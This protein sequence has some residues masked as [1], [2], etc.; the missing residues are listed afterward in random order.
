[1]AVGKPW[2]LND[3]NNFLREKNR[4]QKIKDNP[5]KCLNELKFYFVKTINNKSISYLNKYFKGYDNQ[6]NEKHLSSLI[7]EDEYGNIILD[8]YYNIRLLWIFSLHNQ[9]QDNINAIHLWEDLS[10]EITFQLLIQGFPIETIVIDDYFVYIKDFRLKKTESYGTKVIFGPKILF[11]PLMNFHS[12]IYTII[13]K[14]NIFSNIQDYG[15][16]L[17]DYLWNPV[18][19]LDSS[20]IFLLNLKQGDIVQ[21]WLLLGMI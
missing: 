3:Y 10:R 6:R 21:A 16:E 14:N 9:N 1:M 18:I 11:H 8:G 20:Q 17:Y 4:I 19:G 15:E 7:R 13:N 12:A 5:D 2:D